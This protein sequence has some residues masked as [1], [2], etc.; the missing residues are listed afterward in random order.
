MKFTRSHD[1]VLRA[2]MLIPFRAGV[3]EMTNILAFEKEVHLLDLPTS[4]HQ[5]EL[6]IKKHI[7]LMGSYQ[8]NEIMD[9]DKIT[10]EVV[11]QARIRVLE[12]YPELKMRVHK[13]KK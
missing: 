9:E 7:Y 6:M 4:R 5:A 13:R 2:T 8:E 12:L 3:D 10:D 11:K 1:G